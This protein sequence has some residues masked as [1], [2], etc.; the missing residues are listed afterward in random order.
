MTESEYNQL[1]GETLTRIEHALDECG[2]DID[3]DL[4]AGG[5]L[6]LSFENGSK[7]IVNKQGAAQEIWIAAKS[8][9]FH[10]GWK[11]GAWRS[12]RDG[13]ELFADLGRLASEQAGEAVSFA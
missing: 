4:G 7:I 2:A 10:Y 13:G 12:A 1:A 6:E 9:G 3:Y 5:V 11:D 8:G